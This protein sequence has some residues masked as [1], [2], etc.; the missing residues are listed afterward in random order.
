MRKPS[1]P[2]APRGVNPNPRN[3]PQ[4]IQ[5]QAFS[6]AQQMQ[7]MPM[8]APPVSQIDPTPITPTVAPTIAPP[9]SQYDQT[10][11][12]YI[13]RPQVSAYDQARAA[14]AARAPVSSYDQIRANYKE[15]GY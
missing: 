5:P 10:R 14:L 1:T 4:P 13:A 9:V 7:A 8:A 11:A 12:A 6:R 3:F 15:R 2:A